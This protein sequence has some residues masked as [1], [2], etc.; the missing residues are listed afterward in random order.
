[1][2]DRRTQ[3][4]PRNLLLLSILSF[5]YLALPHIG[6]AAIE[7]PR[8]TEARPSG[9]RTATRAIERR[10]STEWLS[11]VA[12]RIRILEEQ[13]E[14]KASPRMKPLGIGHAAQPREGGD[15]P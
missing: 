11:D 7:A 13:V 1:M 8:S 4:V 15:L 6:G 12:E 2:R 5:E 14:R 10:S 3:R 9:R